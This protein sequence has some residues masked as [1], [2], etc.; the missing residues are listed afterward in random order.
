[1]V[2]KRAPRVSRTPEQVR[3][4][5]YHEAG[6]AAMHWFFG[7]F[8][9]LIHIDM[10]GDE[11]NLAFVRQTSFALLPMMVRG[12][13]L[14]SPCL[15]RATAAKAIMHH[16]SGPCTENRACERDPEWLA[17][18]LDGWNLYPG[19]DAALAVEAAE[20]AFPEAKTSKPAWTLLRR[21]G[22]WVDECFSEPRMWTVVEALANRLATATVMEADEA[23]GVMQQAWGGECCGAPWT[24]GRKWRRRFH[25]PLTIQ[26][27]GCGEG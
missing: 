7:S 10:A 1:M 2:A 5:A 11:R 20:A 18:L 14:I 6:H 8:G 3:L 9:D 26:A 19:S 23:W 22:R 25:S 15:G 12:A 16:L 4:I 27:I 24:M 13:A 17:Y 21:V